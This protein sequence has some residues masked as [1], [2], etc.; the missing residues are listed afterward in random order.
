MKPQG[1]PPWSPTTPTRGRPDEKARPVNEKPT[2][3]AIDYVWSGAVR[4]RRRAIRQWQEWSKENPEDAAALLRRMH[5]TWYDGLQE[6]DL[7]N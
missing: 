7:S 1:F 4:K 3:A 6:Q 2:A 5:R